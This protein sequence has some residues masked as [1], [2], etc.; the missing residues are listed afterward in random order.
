M[1]GLSVGKN[2]CTEG[3]E[4]RGLVFESEARTSPGGTRPLSGV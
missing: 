2:R 1:T 4:V 3:E